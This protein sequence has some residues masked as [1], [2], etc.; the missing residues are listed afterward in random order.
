[1]EYVAK[2][3]CRDCDKKY[4]YPAGL[5]THRKY[6]C[7]KEPQF[8]CPHCSYKAKQKGRHEC[9]NCG[10]NYKHRGTLT[11][12]QKYECGKAPQFL[13]PHCDFKTKRRNLVKLHI[14]TKHTLT[15]MYVNSEY[16]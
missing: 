15:N 6:E 16:K 10:K 1:M 2:Y 3:Q 14:F 5:Y 13:C 8:Q 4:K 12:H 9:R 11:F 7:G